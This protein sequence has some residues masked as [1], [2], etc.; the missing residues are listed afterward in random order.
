MRNLFFLEGY[1]ALARARRGE[2][3]GS[4]GI[5]TRSIEP[6]GKDAEGRSNNT[7]QVPSASKLRIPY[8]TGYLV[9]AYVA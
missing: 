3:S 5:S 2:P 9:S 1:E 7:I 6:N 8:F 4:D